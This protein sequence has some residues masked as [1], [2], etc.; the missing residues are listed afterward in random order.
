MLSVLRAP[1][2]SVLKRVWLTSPFVRPQP[3]LALD[4]ALWYARFSRWCAAHPC[5]VSVSRDAFY[6]DV[7]RDERIHDRIAYLEFGSFAGESMRRAVAFNADPASTFTGFDSFRGL[8]DAWRGYAVGHFDMGGVAPV[9]EDERCRFV[10]GMFQETL[11]GFAG[12]YHPGARQVI[13][14]DAD[15][16]SSTLYALFHMGP[17]LRAGDIIM[18]D[19]FHAWMDEFRAFCSFL[20]VFPLEYTARRRTRDWSQ[21]ALEI[22]ANPFAGREVTATHD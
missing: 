18:F 17:H 14:M 5:S 11:P 9:V 7:W 22:I 13:L 4:K 16:Y 20:L 19:E 6:A 12:R 15:L 8:P 3:A 2:R 1:G 10:A 21:V